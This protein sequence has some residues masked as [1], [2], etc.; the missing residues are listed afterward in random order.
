MQVP[1]SPHWR[2]A[3]LAAALVCGLTTHSRAQTADN[4]DDLAR[5]AEAL[6]DTKPSEAADLYR[7]A[8]A[9]KPDWAEG[10]M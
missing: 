9:L 4:F 3:A 5:R 1:G 2:R 8:L 6:V 7:K 10:W